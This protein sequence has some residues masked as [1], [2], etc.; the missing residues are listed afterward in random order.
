MNKNKNI[1]VENSL[2]GLMVVGGG[3]GVVYTGFCSI[4]YNVIMY[5][6]VITIYLTYSTVCSIM[7]KYM[8]LR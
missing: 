8:F 2:C 7:T 6:E 4:Y 1:L 3:G 5:Y